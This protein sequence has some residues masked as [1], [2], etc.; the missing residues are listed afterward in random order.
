MQLECQ[1][2]VFPLFSITAYTNN[3][4]TEYTKKNSNTFKTNTNFWENTLKKKNSFTA[5]Q[6]NR[7]TGQAVS[8][9]RAEREG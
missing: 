4:E 2:T 6:A 9:L 7:R 5:S 3:I 8:S 1:I